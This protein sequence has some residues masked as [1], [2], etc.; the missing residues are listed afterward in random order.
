MKLL[1]KMFLAFAK[2]GAFTFGGGY[3]M[4]PMLQREIV[5][6]NKWATEDELLNYFAVGQCTPGIIA[7]NTAT[8]VG[9]KEKG[10]SGSIFATLGVIFPSVV[11]ITLISALIQNFLDYRIVQHAMAGIR[12]CVFVLIMS[13]V[14]KLLK[15]S[16]KDIPSILIFSA[17]LLLS[18]FTDISSPVFVV[19]AG[20]VGLFLK[21]GGDEK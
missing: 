12:V 18:V 10:I 1:L 8:F 14:L 11:I 5:E 16:V 19:I 17:V 21:R 20:V 15:K 3:A 4:L 6:K 13:S 7:V 9:Y 2:I